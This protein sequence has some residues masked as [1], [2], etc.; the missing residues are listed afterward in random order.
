[1]GLPNTTPMIAVEEYLEGEK[2]SQLRHEYIDGQIFAMSGG[3]RRHNRIAG[4][5][6]R[7]LSDHFQGGDCE[8]FINDLKVPV[9]PSVF[10]YPDVIATC[11][12]AAENQ[13]VCESP[14]LLIEVISPS[15]E[16]IDR[17]EKAKLYKQ[18]PSLQEYVLVEQ[19]RIA[20]EIHRRNG[21]DG[22]DILRFEDGDQFELTSVALDCNVRDF[23]DG[24]RFD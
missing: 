1:M 2:S 6:Y 4:N 18:L 3:S 5:F 22:W 17:R 15:T 19:D 7:R 12:P 21:N 23:Y 9:G 8:A 11:E 20:I 14:I 24:I 13:Y 16:Q 10:Y